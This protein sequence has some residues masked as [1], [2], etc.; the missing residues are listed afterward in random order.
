[1]YVSEVS[2]R[3]CPSSN[4]LLTMNILALV[5]FAA[6]LFRLSLQYFPS[7][8]DSCFIFTSARDLADSN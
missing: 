2:E 8:G 7:E 3:Y 6:G 4:W 1:M 5:F